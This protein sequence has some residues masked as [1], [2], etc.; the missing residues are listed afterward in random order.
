MIRYNSTHH[1][2]SKIFLLGVLCL[3][4]A[5]DMALAASGGGHGTPWQK[6]DTYRII[7]FLV[8]AAIVFFLIR[9]PAA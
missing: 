3:I 6:T 1:R 4:L 9:K 7:N 5:A 8:L 2:F